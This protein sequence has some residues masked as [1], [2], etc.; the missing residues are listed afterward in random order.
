MDS[1][2]GEERREE[3]VSRALRQPVRGLEAP[4]FSALQESAPRRR[5]ALATLGALTVTAA[6][7]VVSVL[8]GQQLAERRDGVAATPTPTS[9]ASPTQPAASPSPTSGPTLVTREGRQFAYRIDLPPDY[10]I[11]DRYCSPLRLSEER[12]YGQS[13]VVSTSDLSGIG[14]APDWASNIS[15]MLISNSE[16]QRSAMA[17]ARD[18][19]DEWNRNEPADGRLSLEGSQINDQEAARVLWRGVTAFYVVRSESFLFVI[20][21][22]VWSTDQPEGWFD[23]IAS[24]FDVIEPFFAFVPSLVG[25][26]SP[27]ELAREL[28]QAFESGQ[29]GAISQL[30]TPNCWIEGTYRDERQPDLGG[31]GVRHRAVDNFL[32]ELRELIESQQLVV[33][34]DP[35]LRESEDEPDRYLLRSI[36]TSALPATGQ[37]PYELR[38][39]RQVDL[40]LGEMHGRWYWVGMVYRP[41]E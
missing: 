22:A 37:D 32:D 11:S 16:Q 23:E 24:T 29:I 6:V 4:S 21:P 28:A 19:A 39:R 34:V 25:A 15:V 5:G 27:E 9:A 1:R 7:L 13:W 10:R 35:T 33:V 18:F 8:I 41:P 31:V 30:T 12:I 2:Q 36:W 38:G 20:S 14:P 26:A 17:W 3:L 40:L